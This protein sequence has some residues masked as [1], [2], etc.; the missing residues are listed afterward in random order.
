MA[1]PPA[2]SPKKARQMPEIQKK[3]RQD[4]KTAQGKCENRR[5]S[6]ADKPRVA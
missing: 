5:C 3:Q 1:S 2:V 6:Q 4:T